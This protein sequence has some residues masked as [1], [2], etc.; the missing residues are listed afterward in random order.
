MQRSKEHLE[1]LCDPKKLDF[2]LKIA[3][4]KLCTSK[5]RKSELER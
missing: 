1:V 5:P 4:F 3:K 2:G